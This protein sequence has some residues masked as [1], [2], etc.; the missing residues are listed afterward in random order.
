MAPP[1]AAAAAAGAPFSAGA[2]AASA[3]PSNVGLSKEKSPAAAAAAGAPAPGCRAERDGN[4]AGGVCDKQ[5]ARGEQRRGERRSCRRFRRACG[6][7]GQHPPRRARLVGLAGGAGHR[8]LA[9]AERV[10]GD[11]PPGAWRRAGVGAGARR[12]PSR[13]AQ[14]WPRRQPRRRRGSGSG[15]RQSLATCSCR[16]RTSAPQAP[17]LTR[18]RHQLEV[19][20][21]ALLGALQGRNRR[22]TAAAGRA[23]SRRG[24]RGPR[25]RQAPR[26]AQ[27]A[28]LE[29]RGYRRRPRARAAAAPGPPQGQHH[30]R[31][32]GRRPLLRGFNPQPLDK[33]PLNRAHR[34]VHL[35]PLVGRGVQVGGGKVLRGEGELLEEGGA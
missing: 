23:G 9:G 8:V 29:G 33:R 30:G 22:A 1:A 19:G 7:H 27:A 14:R 12:A 16:Q 18:L 4:G 21:A 32:P 5:L 24:C 11:L 10:Q 17:Q 28:G 31:R 15:P 2:A 35:A 25:A 34:V 13:G 26:T 6:V 20:G 3:P